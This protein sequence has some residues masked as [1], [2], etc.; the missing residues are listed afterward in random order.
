MDFNIFITNA[1]VWLVVVARIVEV[2]TKRNIIAGKTKAKITLCLLILAE[3]ALLIGAIM[4][5]RVQ[6]DHQGGWTRSF[7][8]PCRSAGFDPGRLL[9]ISR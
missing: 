3:L 6:L 9:A 4:M 1:M 5:L 2:R 8:M 7:Q